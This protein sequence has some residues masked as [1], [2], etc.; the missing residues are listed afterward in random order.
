MGLRTTIAGMRGALFE[1]DYHRVG[2]MSRNFAFI[3]KMPLIGPNPPGMSH[4]GGFWPQELYPYY[5]AEMVLIIAGSFLRSFPGLCFLKILK[6]LGLKKF[7]EYKG[8]FLKED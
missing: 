2:G 6:F 3:F 8:S 5:I 1:I 4:L 7:W